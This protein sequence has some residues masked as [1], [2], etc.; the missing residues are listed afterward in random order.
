MRRP[1]FTL[2]ELLVVV[3]VIAILAAI[4]VPN[5]LSAS[6]RAKVSRA[7]ADLR[8]LAAGLEAY[9]VDHGGYPLCNAFGT[10]G[11]R[12][13]VV[14]EEYVY[15]EA[16]STPVA[17]LTAS[18][19]P[20]PFPAVGRIAVM[21]AADLPGLPGQPANTGGGPPF[22]A[23]TYTSWNQVSRTT[24]GGGGFDVE[25]TPRAWLLQSNGP[26]QHQFNVGGIL[27]NFTAAQ[28]LDILYDPTNGSISYGSIFRVGGDPGAGYG[29]GFHA[30][31]A[32]QP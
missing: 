14:T 20:D 9:A 28:T 31:V 1:A 19:L 8:T 22:R 4:A 25:D 27:D 30:A 11:N 15:L 24:A 18:I 23:Y 7:R 6:T 21:T 10:P 17:Y 29:S 2:I 32:S 3:A 12:T 13:P 5:L 16:L 26:D